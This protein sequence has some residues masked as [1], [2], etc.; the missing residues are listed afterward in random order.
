MTRYARRRL[1]LGAALMALATVA[2]SG[3]PREGGGGPGGTDTI[4]QGTLPPGSSASASASAAAASASA[5]PGQPGK[6]GATTGPGRTTG[7]GSN[8]G[9]PTTGPYVTKGPAAPP[10]DA[11]GDLQLFPGDLNTRGISPSEI[12]LC[13]H[14]ALT[15]ADAFQTHPS[16]FN[17]FWTDL[18]ARGGIHGRKVTMSYQDDA[19]D[20][21]QAITAAATCAGKNPFAIVGGIGFD[22][23]P[24]VREW[25][26]THRELYLHHDATEKG[27]AGK[28]YSFTSIP[29]VERL[30]EAFAELA[31]AKFKGKKI[32]VLYRDSEFWKPGFDAFKAA[33]GRYGLNVGKLIPVQKNQANYGQQLLAL[34]QDG[35]QVVWAWEN[36][37]AATEMINQ[38][39][40][41]FRPSWMV[42]PFNLTTQ[43]LADRALDIYGIASWPAYSYHDY[44]GPFASYAADIKEFERQYAKWDPN[45]DLSGAGGDLLFLNWVAQK[46]IA[47]L[48]LDCG[49][50]CTRNHFA[51]LL[52]RYRG[53]VSPNC[54]ADFP[55]YGGHLGS[56]AFNV[57][58]SYTGPSGKLGWQPISRCVER[59]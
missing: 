31:N 30:G 26:E 23:I 32:G 28:R 7:P 4:A 36:A 9:G 14:A 51:T 43:T 20:P 19:Y 41:G 58:H 25:A 16:D 52:S 10:H 56:Q 45:V 54:P 59:F 6:P 12:T 18:N 39:P 40:P 33:A 49:P 13:A 1:R 21:Q 37:L 38:A 42:F 35:T 57:F 53:T 34:Q 11:P 48:L 22:Q 24:G 3:A 55:R 50:A 8:G 29:T 44:S 46:A 2:C 5:R 27:L 17:V 15:Y 47:Q